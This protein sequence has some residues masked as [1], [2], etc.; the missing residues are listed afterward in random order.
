MANQ[1]RGSRVR[2]SAIFLLAVCSL[3][4]SQPPSPTPT[5]AGQERQKST[6]EVQ[7]PAKYHEDKSSTDW[8]MRIFTGLIFLATAVQAYI[9]WRQKQLMRNAL[10]ETKKAADAATKS[11][12]VADK[13][14]VHTQR[15]FVH[16][17]EFRTET[18][19]METALSE[20]LSRSLAGESTCNGATWATHQ[21]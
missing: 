19:F 5:G 10:A 8:W 20:D 14:L 3:A 7:D 4:Q 13:A 6:T 11:A 1:Q 16:L 17:E 2:I 9:Y 12:E 15:A 18:V 21:P